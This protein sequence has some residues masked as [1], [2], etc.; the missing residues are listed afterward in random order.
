MEEYVPSHNNSP[1]TLPTAAKENLSG[2]PQAQ[3]A[4]SCELKAAAFFS[5]S[6]DEASLYFALEG[7]DVDQELTEL[8]VAS[9]ESITHNYE[10]SL[11]VC[12]ERAKSIVPSE[13]Y[14]QT[15]ATP[16]LQNLRL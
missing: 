10:P 8:A 4:A 7:V 15:S 1:Q 9:T 12:T 14:S 16:A 6:A 3:T 11:L 5:I 2:S 13:V